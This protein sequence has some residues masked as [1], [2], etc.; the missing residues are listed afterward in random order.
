MESD[1]IKSVLSPSLSL[2]LGEYCVKWKSCSLPMHKQT[3]S[4]EQPDCLLKNDGWNEITV[5][6]IFNSTYDAAENRSA[7]G[8]SPFRTHN[9]AQCCRLSACDAHLS[10]SSFPHKSATTHDPGRAPIPI[11][12]NEQQG[13]PSRRYIF[14]R[15][16][17]RCQDMVGKFQ[18]Q[19]HYKVTYSRSCSQ[20]KGDFTADLPKFFDGKETL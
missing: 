13:W 19:R 9:L 16:G 6:G 2:C 20:R 11:A 5:H 7:A 17:T 10:S 18:V 8:S 4:R 3:V 12:F 14:R 15:T 1:V